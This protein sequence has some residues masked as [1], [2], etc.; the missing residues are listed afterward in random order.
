M[1]I[2]LALILFALPL[3]A[4]TVISRRYWVVPLDTLAIGHLQHTHVETT[5]RVKYC[6]SEEDW[7]KHVRLVSLTDST[8]FVIVEWAPTWDDSLK[9]WKRPTIRCPPVGAII[10]V[11]GI[12]RMDTEHL[13]A[14]IHVAEMPWEY[15]IF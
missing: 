7:D 14:E 15:F 11:R 2:L 4:Q 1:R 8:K 13:W 9:V 12:T 5:G 6:R 3:E 10:T